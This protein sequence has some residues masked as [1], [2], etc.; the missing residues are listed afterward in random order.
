MDAA[1]RIA[2]AYR[3]QRA[4]GL[5]QRR[6]AHCLLVVTPATPDVWDANHAAAVTAEAPEEVDAVFAAIDRAFAP[7][8]HRVVHTDPFTPPAFA[9]ELAMRDYAPVSTVVQMALAEPALPGPAATR[10]VADEAGW[11]ALAELARANLAEQGRGAAIAEG[12]VAGYRAKAPAMR[13]HLVEREGRA[14]AYGAAIACPRGTG[15]IE[16]LFTLP[17]FRR[18]GIASGLVARLAAELAGKGCD[19]IFLGAFADDAPKHLYRRLGFRPAALG[20][21]WVRTVANP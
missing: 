1:R 13:F 5:T 14:V 6:E 21:C 8:R 17:E 2:A 12:L 18:R 19:L 9:A 7:G 10:E 11:R 4:L 16:H 20:Q 3:W 15:M